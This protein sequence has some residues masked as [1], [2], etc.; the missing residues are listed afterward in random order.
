MAR[1]LS[2]LS[3]T[4]TPPSYYIQPTFYSQQQLVSA[5]PSY[6][7]QLSEYS[8]ELSHLASP[9][10][11]YNDGGYWEA[12]RNNAV[13]YIGEQAP[14]VVRLETVL[15]TTDNY[16]APT[17]TDIQPSGIIAMLIPPVIRQLRSHI[18]SSSI[19]LLLLHILRPP[20]P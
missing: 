17:T 11:P 20:L 6:N 4:A 12:E 16:V 2:G 15:Y 7:S 10:T 18:L 1:H 13:R 5:I 9:N 8:Q 3:L 19:R 14:C